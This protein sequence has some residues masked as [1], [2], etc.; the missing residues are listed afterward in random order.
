MNFGDGANGQY[1]TNIESYIQDETI[2][3]ITE[4]LQTITD[5]VTGLPKAKST[6]Y[7]VAAG[8]KN[9][10]V[11][12]PEVR[13]VAWRRFDI[14][15]CDFED[16]VAAFV[17]EHMNNCNSCE[18]YQANDTA[19]IQGAIPDDTQGFYPLRVEGKDQISFD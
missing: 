13:T 6:S 19:V 9:K 17:S 1:F 7:P 10:V 12:F 2:Q 4:A 8:E 18:S 11:V 14:D 16:Q 5:S 15:A 3:D